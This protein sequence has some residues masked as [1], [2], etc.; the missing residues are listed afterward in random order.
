MLVLIS[1]LMLRRGAA[2]VVSYAFSTQN[3]KL[4][5]EY[6]RLWAICRP[7][8]KKYLYCGAISL[9]HAAAFMY[10]PN[11]Y[12]D[13]NTLMAL[14]VSEVAPDILL[15][16][17]A[18]KIGKWTGI[19]ATLGTLTYLRRYEFLD[20]S[21]RISVR[22]RTVLYSHVMTHDFYRRNLYTQACVHHLVTDVKSLSEFT[23]ETVFMGVRGVFFLTGGICCLLY[24]SPYVSLI[25]IGIMSVFNL[26]FR[27]R[28]T[29]LKNLKSE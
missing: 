27:S 19:F 29:L 12:E 7:E 3:I 14:R 21:N 18:A 11:I 4:K 20:V 9:V 22:L 15:Q 2:N 10:L 1:Q 8:L 5:N 26:L 17:Y 24:T 23:G 28:N 6:Q 25:A 13:I 16:T